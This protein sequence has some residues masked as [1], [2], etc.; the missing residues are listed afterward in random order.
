MRLQQ[1]IVTNFRKVV[2][3]QAPLCR[4]LHHLAQSKNSRLD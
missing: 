4:V 1:I 3:L 2:K